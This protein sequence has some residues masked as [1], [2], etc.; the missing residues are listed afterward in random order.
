MQPNCPSGAPAGSL[1]AGVNT[2]SYQGIVTLG[3]NAINIL[4]GIVGAL[5]VIFILV[6][7]LQYVTSTGDPGRSER[8][9]RTI[10]FAVSGLI[11]AISTYAIVNL[12]SQRFG[13]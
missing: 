4:L 13:I 11:L 2:C 3:Q 7:A 1:F 10:I 8:A 6:G 12:I 5:A 9:K